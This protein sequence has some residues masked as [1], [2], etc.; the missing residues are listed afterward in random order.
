MELIH[1]G[2]VKFDKTLFKPIQN[3]YAIN[4]PTGGFWTSPKNSDRG[5]KNW[6]DDANFG[7]CLQVKCTTVTLSANA[8]I[9]KIDSLLDLINI[10][11]TKTDKYVIFNETVLDYETIALHY[12]AIWLTAK[13]LSETH[14]STPM[15]LYGWDCE[16]VL[17]MNP[18]C[19]LTRNE[20]D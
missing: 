20:P 14:L 9:L 15:D 12:D 5:W 8:K 6:C 4:K 10:P 11:Y 2:C 13:G 1:Y 19:I 16:T 17:V 3:R 18:D 7:E